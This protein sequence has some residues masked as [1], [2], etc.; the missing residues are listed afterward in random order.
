LRTIK[1][2]KRTP[3]HR[4][5]AD[6]AE[7]ADYLVVERDQL[8][9]SELQG[10]QFGGVNLCLIFVDMEPGGGPRLH[11][12]AYEEVFVIL[13]GQAR[14]TVGSETVDAHAGQVLMVRPRVAHK[15]V[16][17]GSG[18]LRQIDIHASPK[19]VTEW[20]ED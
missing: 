10:Y 2:V 4:A 5:D 15:F 12:H 16:N 18:R 20:L 13:E 3:S 7:A 17:V 11:R 19:F 1:F 9:E 8:P 6:A 14:F